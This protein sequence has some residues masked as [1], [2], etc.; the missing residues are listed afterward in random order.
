MY[1]SEFDKIL[2]RGDIPKAIMFFGESLFFID[3]YIELFKSRVQPDEVTTFYNFDY[4]FQSAKSSISQGSLFA[5]R[6]MLIIKSEKEIANSELQEL[7]KIATSSEDSYFLYIFYGDRTPKTQKLFSPNFVRFFNPN[8]Y[9]SRNILL[10]ESRRAG[11]SI[12]IQGIDRLIYRTNNNLSIAIQELEK[13]SK[14]QKTIS[15]GDIDEFVTPPIDIG[16]D[17]YIHHFLRSGEYRQ[18]VS[19]IETQSIDEV[20]IFSY[21]TKYLEEIYYFRTALE[22]GK[23]LDSLSIL[24]RK[25]PPKVERE[26]VEMAKKLD[27]ELIAQLLYLMAESELSLKSGEVKDKKMFLIQKL[28]EIGKLLK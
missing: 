3:R 28:V 14:L 26:R 24:G 22:S 25:L 2:Q 15:I 16:L 9:E 8:F 21:S 5:S 23:K 17:R 11:V 27:L 4:N 1:R 12:P 6:Q 13:L 10:E 19:Y 18:L 20:A 7:I